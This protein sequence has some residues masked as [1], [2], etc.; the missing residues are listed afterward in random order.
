MNLFINR[1]EELD[2]LNQ[3]YQSKK[4]EFIVVYGR[5]RVGKSEL[6]KQFSKGKPSI[7]FLAT[8][9]TKYHH[10]KKFLAKTSSFFEEYPPEVDTW[11]ECFDYIAKKIKKKKIVLV[12]DE[13]PYLIESNK[14]IPSLF[15]LFWDEY[16]KE[17]KIFLILSGSS[18]AMME[19]EVLSKKSP[20]YGR[21]TGQIRLLPFKF[22]DVLKFYPKSSIEN[23]VEFYSVVGS[24]PMYLLEFD[25]DKDVFSNI[26]EKI[27][28]K[29]EL[30]N[31]E[32][33]FL[34][35]EELR[36]PATYQAILEAIAVSTKTTEIAQ[37]AHLELHNLDKYLKVL[38]KL[39]LIYKEAPVTIKKPKSRKV[40][41]YIKDNFLD[42]W[43]GFCFPNSSL[44]EENP[45]LLAEKI[46]KPNL[47][48]YVGRK[49]EKIGKEF[50]WELNRKDKLPFVFTKI[51][52][53]WGKMPGVSKDRNQYEIDL[54]ALNEKTKE[55]LFGE[56]KW[57]EKVN[58]QKV[59]FELK[60]K[61]GYV[62]WNLGKRKEYYFI[63]AKSFTKKIK[64]ACC[65]DLKELE[66][67]F[68]R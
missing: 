48:K 30:L 40:Y 9:T 17:K 39:D 65:F 29:K 8:R 5:R 15:Q 53:Q 44:M 13:F 25:Q 36:D 34:L 19:E 18:I 31:E 20:L 35:K 4:A 60:K 47:N 11:E 37:K 10:L 51:G 59:L 42:F 24:I 7:Y 32:V 46:I 64:E 6:I 12:I 55:I 28:A 23:V 1:E 58:P 3:R 49:F 63:F 66:K 2:F 16:L 27:L 41:Y 68:L 43:Y 50:L 52:R 61:A 57:Q 54:V 14:E 22:R 38:M 45:N 21:R 67:Q 26:R 62:D 56:C 33:D